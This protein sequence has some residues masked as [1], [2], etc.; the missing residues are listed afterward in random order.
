MELAA[1]NDLIDDLESL[2]RTRV[3]T[4]DDILAV[5]KDYT[6]EYKELMMRR[7][8][9]GPEEAVSP[10]IGFSLTESVEVDGNLLIESVYEGGPAYQVGM[11]PGDE[12]VAMENRRVRTI[13]D[14]KKA[15]SCVCNVGRVTRITVRRPDEG[16]YVANVW[17]MTSDP[18]QSGKSYFFD[19]TTHNQMRAPKRSST[20]SSERK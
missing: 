5:T 4:D 13:A 10:F 8:V 2:E 7:E 15:V 16:F 20:R 14:A 11:R 19:V 17:I 9:P 1:R 6:R 12:V 3:V 18:R